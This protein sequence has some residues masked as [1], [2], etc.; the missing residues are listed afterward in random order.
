VTRYAVLLRAV[1]VGGRNKL[2]MATLRDLAADLGYSDPATYVQSGNLVIGATGTKPAAIEKRVA[3]ALRDGPGLDVDVIVRSR[4][5][6][7][8]AVK[9]NPFADIA[10]DPAKMH[11]SFLVSAPSPAKVKALDTAEF[12]PERFAVGK[13]CLYL[14]YPNGQGRSAMAAAPWNRRLGVAGT[15]RNLR[16]VNKLIDMLAG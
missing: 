6:L 10:D 14:W 16:T 13:R 8:A 7:A 5:E 9:A 2:P 15:A 11:I 4:A 12:E 3:A 1:N